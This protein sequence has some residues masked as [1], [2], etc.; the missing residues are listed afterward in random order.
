M[1]LGI[2]AV[3]SLVFGLLVGTT[4]VA[5]TDHSN[6]IKGPFKTGPDVTKAC[7]QCHQ[8]QAQDFMKTVHWTW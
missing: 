3:A 5:A 2:F 8:N 7:L 6:F 1:K 4:A